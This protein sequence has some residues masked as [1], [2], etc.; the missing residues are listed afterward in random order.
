MKQQWNLGDFVKEQLSRVYPLRRENVGADARLAKRGM[1]FETEVYGL[2]ELGHLCILRMRAP[3]GLM[4]METVVLSCT[5]RDVPLFNLD[6]VRVPGKETAIAELYDTQLEA[7]P[8]SAQDDFTRI[9]ARYVDVADAAAAGAHWFD[10]VLYPCSL[11][12]TGRGVS[13]RLAEASEEYVRA[14]LS[15]LETAEAC[16]AEAKRAK[17]RAFAERLLAEGGPAVNQVTKLFG[18]EIA[19]RLILRHMYG[20]GAI[21]TEEE[22]Q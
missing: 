6:R 17:V 9:K 13:A 4:S 15:Q 8:Q 20:V 19:E 5:H 14:F 18:S 2:E 7:W 22:K 11:H 16:D 12:K 10:A 3:L 1:A 21:K